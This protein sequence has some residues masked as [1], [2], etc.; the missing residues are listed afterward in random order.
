MEWLCNRY[1]YI[2]YR[3]WSSALKARINMTLTA[4]EISAD[5]HM[6]LHLILGI[7][8]F[9]ATN[10][11]KTAAV[12][13]SM[14]WLLTVNVVVFSWSEI[15]VHFTSV[16]R[17]CGSTEVV[18][19]CS[20]QQHWYV[21]YIQSA[22]SKDCGSC[23]CQYQ[24]VLEWWSGKRVRLGIHVGRWSWSRRQR[25]T[26]TDISCDF[27]NYCGN[28]QAKDIF[29]MGWLYAFSL[30]VRLLMCEPTL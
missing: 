7:N 9:H 8:F 27:N 23:R 2:D 5:K 3:A 16:V 1:I 24:C 22:T 18:G 26:E 30:F 4:T 20:A 6:Q 13:S 11:T 29:W 21:C 25:N 12:L 17:F 19:S 14:L 10:N 15:C 28:R